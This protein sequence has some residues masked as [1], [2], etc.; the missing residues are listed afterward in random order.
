MSR[1]KPAP[2]YLNEAAYPE[3]RLK[4]LP[5]AP[6]LPGAATYFP[7]GASYNSLPTHRNT[8]ASLARQL[9]QA[10]SPLAGLDTLAPPP[11][12]FAFTE[13]SALPVMTAFR[14]FFSQLNQPEPLFA[15]IHAK[16]EKMN[17]LEQR[18]NEVARLRACFNG[19]A[20]VSVVD[21]YVAV[22]LTAATAAGLLH[23]SGVRH[24]SL[25]RGNWFEYA[26]RDEFDTTIPT[27][28]LHQ[29]FFRSVGLQ[30]F[31]GYQAYTEHFANRA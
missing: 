15:T 1:S 28:D 29:D 3:I 18:R 24:I 31:E 26:Y 22:G 6:S 10:L 11:T 13:Y 27:H 23:Q 19:H 12:A 16:P 30:A 25:I 20:H 8:D 2:K 4:M 7:R 21:Q 9:A 5:I 17:D 14:S